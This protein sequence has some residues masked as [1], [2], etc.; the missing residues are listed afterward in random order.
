M[1]KT[2]TLDENLLR[3]AEEALTTSFANNELGEDVVKRLG[4]DGIISI[5]LRHGI[6]TLKSETEIRELNEARETRSAAPAS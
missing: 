4:P 6:R 3:E 2:I 5:V 1:P